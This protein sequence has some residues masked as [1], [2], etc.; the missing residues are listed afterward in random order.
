MFN[1]AERLKCFAFN[2]R[3]VFEAVYIETGIHTVVKRLVF[4]FCNSALIL[5][6]NPDGMDQFCKIVPE[7]II[8][9]H[10]S[11]CKHSSNLSV[12]K[13]NKV[14]DIKATEVS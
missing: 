3:L 11:N 7:E 9:H 5:K 13:L 6:K 12:K 4:D 8:R 1:K 10:F 14:S 2:H